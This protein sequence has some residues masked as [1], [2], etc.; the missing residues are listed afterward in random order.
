MAEF[1]TDFAFDNEPDFDHDPNFATANEPVVRARRTIR[2]TVI[3]GARVLTGAIGLGVAL[4]V[5]AAV[6]LIPFPIIASGAP[7]Q[8]ITPLPAAQELV[9]PGAVLRLGN[10]QGQN[11]TT[12]SAIGSPFVVSA[13]SGKKVTVT[14][15]ESSDASTGGKSSAPRSLRVAADPAGG[16]VADLLAG[17]QAQLPVASDFTGLAATSCLGAT[18]ESWLVGGSTAV[19]RTTLVTLANPSDVTS[20]VA[21]TIFGENGIIQASGATG[22]IVQPHGQRVLSLAGFAPATTSPTVRVVSRG[23]QIVAHLQ[24]S[25][26]RGLDAGGVDF[27]SANAMPSSRQVIPGVII[28]GGLAVAASVGAQGFEDLSTAIRV[29]AP[30]RQ[31]SSAT[32]TLAPDAAQLVDGAPA[33]G[34]SFVVNLI[35]SRVMDIPLEDVADGTYTITVEAE[36]PIVASA[37]VSVVSPAVNSTVNSTINSAAN[38]AVNGSATV[39]GEAA[40]PQSSDFTWLAASPELSGRTIVAIANGPAPTLHFRNEG[41]ADVTVTMTTR[42]GTELTVVVPAQGGASLAVSAGST[43]VLD[44]SEALYGAVSFLGDA[45]ISGYSIRP[46]AAESTPI[47]VYVK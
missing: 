9:C 12:A 30:G 23:G 10:E 11:A 37:R 43:Y 40:R 7:A 39:S 17:A 46:P 47:S 24:Q 5:I 32:I 45:Q 4:V 3:I 27:V 25:T 29:L 2:G 35:A 1:D 6:G 28:S 22:I 41:K 21:L 44:G 13:S 15:F 31:N 34:A 33:G 26:V 20:T 16:A 36:V 38:S 42:D 14:R 18:T 8:R 19:G